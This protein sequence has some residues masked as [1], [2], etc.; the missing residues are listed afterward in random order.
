MFVSSLTPVTDEI[1]VTKVWRIENRTKQDNWL[2]PISRAK[3]STLLAGASLAAGIFY[4][5]KIEPAW[6]E[7]TSRS[8]L[9]PRLDREFSSIPAEALRTGYRKSKEAKR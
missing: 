2:V 1:I 7:V 4:A 9:L 5:W 6:V 3:T 8:I